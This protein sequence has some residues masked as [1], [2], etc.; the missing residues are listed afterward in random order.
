MH[1]VRSNIWSRTRREQAHGFTLVELMI[2]LTII[3]AMAAMSVPAFQRAVVQS[4][5][6]IAV[7]NLRAIWS[8]ERLYWLEYHTYTPASHL[9]T[10]RDLGLLDRD[11]ASDTGC[12]GYDYS[13]T[14]TNSAPDPFVATAT[15][16]RGSISI[17]IS[18]S[19]RVQYNGITGGIQ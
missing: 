12:A 1:T 16:Q 7:A 15:S 3:A 19:G 2:V 10:L 6:D 8:A 11:I 5:A 4:Q 18:E 9:Q 14:V 17:T 13:V